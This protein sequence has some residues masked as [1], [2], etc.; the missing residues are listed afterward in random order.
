MTHLAAKCL[1]IAK[2]PGAQFKR[3]IPDEKKIKNFYLYFLHPCARLS[4]EN[5]IPDFLFKRHKLDQLGKTRAFSKICDFF[6]K[7]PDFFDENCVPWK[8]PAHKIFS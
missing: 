1:H 8:P 3:N 7:M 2:A 5:E 6:Q 4:L